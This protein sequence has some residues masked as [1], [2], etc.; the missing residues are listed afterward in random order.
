MEPLATLMRLELLKRT[1]LHADETPLVIL[2]AKE[3]GKARKGY[4][5]AY[6]S[7]EKTGPAIVCFD[8]QPGRAAKYPQAYLSGWSG[9]LVSDGY[10]AYHPLNN[11]GEV[12]N[13]ACW[14]HAR[15]G[16]ADLFKAN[17]DPCVLPS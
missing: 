12:V 13:V 5:W 6:V 15:R 7:G 3:G 11:G 4:L 16:F 14:A 1:V 8:S 2:D 10:A 9:S 17:Q